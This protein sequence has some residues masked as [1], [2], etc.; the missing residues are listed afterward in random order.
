MRL[1][2]WLVL[3]CVALFGTACNDRADSPPDAA[4]MQ[5]GLTPGGG[6][7]PPVTV[8]TTQAANAAVVDVTLTEYEIGLSRD[9][10]PAGTIT[11]NIRNGGTVPHAFRIFRGDDEWETDAYDPGE[12][13]SMS[14]ALEPGT[15]NIHCP[16]TEG[17]TSHT[18]RGMQRTLR[19]Y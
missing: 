6:D 15:Y 17:A 2:G 5:P 7:L 16:V 1:R 19:V 12:S 14:I 10:V 3:G 4:D 8:D 11:F 9:S 13:I 18:Q